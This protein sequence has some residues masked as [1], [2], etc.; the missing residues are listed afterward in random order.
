MV[1]LILLAFIFIL[2]R[3]WLSSSLKRN[4]ETLVNMPF[5]GL[6]FGE[7]LLKENDLENVSITE[8]DS[9]DHYDLENREVRVLEDRLNRKSITSIAV[10]CHEIGHAIQHKE[11]YPPL[12]R[13]YKIAKWTE[14]LTKLSSWIFFIGIP[15]IV[16]TG[17]LPLIRVCLII[18][19]S[20]VL[21]SMIIHLIT[22]DVEL[23]A[24]FKK[25]MPILE[26]K[27]PQEYHAAS[28]SILRVCAFTYV[29]ASLTRI[30][31][32]RNLWLFVRMFLFRR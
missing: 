27:I 22:L 3:V 7:L 20:S 14:I 31:N 19:F 15:A 9:V 5:N 11:K 2:P 23:D 17:A 21:I 13:R 12:E 1:Y 29:I 30:L 4:D 10:I 6:Q 16:A 8:T 32:V 24:S 25:A 18:V 26:T 28:K